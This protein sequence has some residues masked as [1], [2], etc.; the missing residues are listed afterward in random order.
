[1]SILLLRAGALALALLAIPAAA[2]TD[3]FGGS[4][5]DTVIAPCRSWS[6]ITPSDTTDLTTV[7]KAIYVGGTGD[8]TMIGV[9]APSGATG[10]A[11]KAVPAASVLP[12]RPRRVLATG[13]TATLLVACY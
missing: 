1:M 6:M 3:R 12:V 8:V 2:Q 10:V 9:D 13:T 11:W 4:F 7:P 5:S